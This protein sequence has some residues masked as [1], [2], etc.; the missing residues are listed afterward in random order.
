MGCF[1]VEVEMGRFLSGGL[2]M[3][4]RAVVELRWGEVGDP[5]ARN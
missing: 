4:A 2:L 5:V 1:E 3:M